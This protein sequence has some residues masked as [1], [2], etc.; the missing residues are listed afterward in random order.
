VIFY[1]GAF[2]TDVEYNGNANPQVEGFRYIIEANGL[3]AGT[4]YAVKAYALSD[5]V[6]FE[7][8]YILGSGRVSGLGTINLGGFIDLPDGFYDWQ[9]TVED[10]D[11]NTILTT[12]PAFMY[13]D[14]INW[15]IPLPFPGAPTLDVILYF[16]GD[17][18]DFFIGPVPVLP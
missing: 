3:T 2:T 12:L 10:T 16:A 5:S 8:D 11:G 14:P 15:N 9:I 6:D 4:N 18:V 13:N 1:C 7:A 17:S